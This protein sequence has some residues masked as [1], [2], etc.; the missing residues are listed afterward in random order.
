[1]LSIFFT[2]SALQAVLQLI[3]SETKVLLPHS[4]QYSV[5]LSVTSSTSSLQFHALVLLTVFLSAV[6]AVCT[7]FQYVIWAPSRS[8]CSR[9]TPLQV[10]PQT[11]ASSVLLLLQHG[12]YTSTVQTLLPHPGSASSALTHQSFLSSQ[13]TLFT[14]LCSFSL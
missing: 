13:S 14:F 6:S 11:H 4:L 1:M 12:S 10:C 7:H 8:L 2:I 3:H 5:M 9:L